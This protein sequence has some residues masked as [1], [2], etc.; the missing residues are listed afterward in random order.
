[1]GQKGKEMKFKYNNDQREEEVIVETNMRIIVS[2]NDNVDFHIEID[3][4]GELE[5]QKVNYGSGGSGIEIKP[6]VSNSITLK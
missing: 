1:M 6:N 2:L 5:I 3:Q 4:F